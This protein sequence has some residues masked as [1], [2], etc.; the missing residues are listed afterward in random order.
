MKVEIQSIENLSGEL[1][2][3]ILG[4]LNGKEILPVTQISKYWNSI[5]KETNHA[6][7]GKLLKETTLKSN[8]NLLKAVSNSEKKMELAVFNFYKDFGKQNAFLVITG[9]TT[10]LFSIFMLAFTPLWL[11]RD[12]KISSGKCVLNTFL[13][14]LLNL[15]AYGLFQAH[16]IYRDSPCLKEDILDY[17]KNTVPYI[18]NN[19]KLDENNPISHKEFFQEMNAIKQQFTKHHNELLNYI[20]SRPVD[21]PIALID[22]IADSE[23]FILSEQLTNLLFLNITKHNKNTVPNIKIERIEETKNKLDTL[24]NQKKVSKIMIASQSKETKTNTM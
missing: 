9:A 12:I 8:K 1:L 7:L 10:I 11:D 16:L 2:L 3:E 22:G 19:K 21:T 23:H 15:I 20:K 18:G 17:N 13:L 4:Y 6:R 24:F 5:Y 14:I